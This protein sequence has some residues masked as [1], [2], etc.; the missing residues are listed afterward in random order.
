MSILPNE[1]VTLR[2]LDH[3]ENKNC[4]NLHVLFNA[5]RVHRSALKHKD[6]TVWGEKAANVQR[7]ALEDLQKALQHS[8]LLQKGAAVPGG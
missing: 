1:S 3:Q 5:C 7:T 2:R 8:L 4:A 6:W